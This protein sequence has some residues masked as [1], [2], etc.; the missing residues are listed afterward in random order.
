MHGAGVYTDHPGDCH[1][2][3][4]ALQTSSV[5]VISTL[6]WCSTAQGYVAQNHT[7]KHDS[8]I[9]HLTY[10]APLEPGSQAVVGLT[11]TAM[12]D[13]AGISGD[14]SFCQI[15]ECTYAGRGSVD[16]QNNAEVERWQRRWVTSLDEIIPEIASPK[17]S[18]KVEAVTKLLKLAM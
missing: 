18:S 16:A 14:E 2:C 17:Q 6:V 12:G 1:H 3:E 13:L 9:P 8:F 5:Q 11:S 4:F 10:P 7:F 15:R